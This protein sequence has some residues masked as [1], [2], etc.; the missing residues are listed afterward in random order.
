M[1]ELQVSTSKTY[2][3]YA[4]SDNI[5]YFSKNDS[6]ICALIRNSHSQIFWRVTK[7]RIISTNTFAR[8]VNLFEYL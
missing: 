7:K 2:K 6:F 1:I 5:P 3:N 8:E 4:D